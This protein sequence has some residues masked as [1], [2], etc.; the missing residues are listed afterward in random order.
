MADRSRV[1]VIT[2][3]TGGIGRATTRRLA[4]RR[5]RI[6]LLARGDAG[7]KGA[8]ADAERWGAKALPIDV[9]VADPKAVDVAASRIEDALGP[10]DVW[11]ND[12]FTSVFAP[13]TEIGLEEF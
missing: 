5:D 9:D 8:A 10:I 6:A 7:L 3:A 4:A 11:I 12:A 1:V 2:G 13:F